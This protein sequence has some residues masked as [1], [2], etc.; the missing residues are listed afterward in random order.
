METIFAY[1]L[2]VNVLIV[3]F[4]LVYQL[5]LSRETFYKYSRWFL[6]SGLLI[7]LVLPFITI[8]R[9]EY[10]E[11]KN[12]ISD[13]IENNMPQMVQISNEVAQKPMFTN[14]EILFLIYGI[15]C[16]GFL[17]KTVL[18]FF[19]LFKIIKVSNSEKKDKLVYINTNLVHT[20]FSFFN[21]IIFNEELINPVE[22][23]NIMKHE[24]AHSMQKHSFDTL[25]AQFFIILFWFNPIVW[26]YRKSIVQNLEFLADSYAIAQVS[27]RTVYQKTMLKITTQSSNITIINTFNQSSIKKRI[28]MLNTNQ[29]NRKNALKYAIVIP[30]LVAFIMLF[31]VKVIAK[32][33]ISNSFNQVQQKQTNQK[34]VVQSSSTDSELKEYSEQFKRD[35]KIDLN[36]KGIKR[37]S[38]KEITAIN[39]TLNDNKGKKANHKVDGDEV[40]EPIYINISKG[41]NDTYNFAI[42]INEEEEEKDV[43]ISLS[44]VPDIESITEI[45]AMEV[46]EMPEP[47]VLDVDFPTPP[48]T[49][50]M[51]NAPEPPTNPNDKKG[52]AKFEK[53]MTVFEKNMKSKDGDW[54]KFEMEMKGFEEKMKALGPN[55]KKFEQEMKVFEEKME[56]QGKKMEKRIEKQIKKEMKNSDLENSKGPKGPKKIKV[57]ERIEKTEKE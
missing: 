52:W 34:Y 12:V 4:Y 29:S 57:I 11:A 33:R 49:P 28:I 27:D 6:L 55:M 40:I 3:I 23:Q 30:V 47:P 18:D 53:D 10:Y 1:I 56:L 54:K 14:Q 9:I 22:L 8:T 37:N 44:E 19:K 5:L 21:Y 46:P 2:K 32:E 45:V 36:F 7:S 48:D 16:F 31:Q 50:D 24:E 20:P 42:G 25:L 26:L 51:P 39:I 43:D 17:I 13:S 15:I 38:D 41:K 35:Y